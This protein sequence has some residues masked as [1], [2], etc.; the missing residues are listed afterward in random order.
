VKGVFAWV[1]GG[2]RFGADIAK[3]FGLATAGGI[4][5]AVAKLVV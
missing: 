2:R 1:G 4:L 5:V 3:V